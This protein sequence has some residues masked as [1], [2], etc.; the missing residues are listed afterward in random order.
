MGRPQS[1]H[2]L[3][4]SY[5]RF[6]IFDQL[7]NQPLCAFAIAAVKRDRSFFKLPQKPALICAV[8][9]VHFGHFRDRPFDKGVHGFA[10]AFRMRSQRVLP[11]LR[12]SNGDPVKILAVP[13]PVRVFSGFRITGH[14]E[15]PLRL[16]ILYRSSAHLT[17]AQH[18]QLIPCFVVRYSGSCALSEC[19]ITEAVKKEK[20]RTDQDKKHHADAGGLIHLP[21]AIGRS[22]PDGLVKGLRS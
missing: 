22:S 17:S 9:I 5:I 19:T 18:A 16:S 21:F 14:N 2:F 12:Q 10:H 7:S 6:R 3:L 4:I 15:P 11:A 8:H 20:P 1:V 13:I